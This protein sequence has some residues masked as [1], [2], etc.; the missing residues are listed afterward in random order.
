M[1]R[2]PEPHELY[3]RHCAEQER[4]AKS[5][6]ICGCCENPILDDMCFEINGEYICEHCINEYYKVVTPVEY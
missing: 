4:L 3:D 6:P 1:S 5:R 2:L